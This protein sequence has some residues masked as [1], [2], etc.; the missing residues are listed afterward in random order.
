MPSKKTEIIEALFRAKTDHRT[1]ELRDTVV[2]RTELMEAIRSY[3]Q[4]RPEGERLSPGNPANF[5]KD[6]VRKRSNQ[7][8]PSAVFERGYTGRQ[9]AGN[10]AVFEFVPVAP[11]QA[12]PFPALG[13]DVPPANE[14]R[15]VESLSLPLASRRLGR[16][17]EPWLAQVAIRLRLIELHLATCSPRRFLQLDHLQMSVKL[18]KSEIDALFLGIED[19]GEG[20]SR[21]VLVTCEAKALHDEIVLEQIQRQV[22]AVFAMRAVTQ[23]EIIPVALKALG[24]SLVHVVEFEGVRREEAAP[25]LRVVS[26]ALYELTPPVPG[27]GQT[28]RSGGDAPRTSRRVRR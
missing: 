25:D 3:N 10:D 5:L 18:R 26:N 9:K 7:I 27:I 19:V 15:K 21:E 4:G 14:A 22:T 11:G 24:P 17:D 6:V 16:S 23:E 1:G 20:R 12:E 2:T 8:W 28:N 13:I